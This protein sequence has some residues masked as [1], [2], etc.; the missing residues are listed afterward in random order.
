MR[1]LLAASLTLL[2]LAPA[3]EAR[4]R[5]LGSSLKG[6]PDQAVARPVDSAFW[7]VRIRGARPFR[8]PRAG[9]VLAIRLKGIARRPD[10][11]PDPF[12]QVHFQTLVPL[13]G[14]AMRVMLT[15][16][17]FLVPIGG[18]PRQ[19]T[20]YRPENLCIRKGGVVDFN[21]SGGFAPPFYPDGVPFRVFR[22]RAGSITARYTAA[23]RT[24]NGDTLRPA[25]R[26]GSELML[27]YV[28]GTGRHLGGACRAYLQG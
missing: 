15:S 7:P 14:G 3:A 28:L 11:A 27:Q 1:R 26:R 10:G 22:A 24:N 5:V 23:D 17:A 21:D 20:T 12:N 18:S 2:L 13:G 8:A 4:L 9:Q 25:R 16:A 19:V 6:T